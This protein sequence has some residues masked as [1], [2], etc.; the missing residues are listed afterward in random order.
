MANTRRKITIP[1]SNGRIDHT[2]PRVDRSKHN[3][4][5][6]IARQ[7]GYEI[8]S[9]YLQVIVPSIAKMASTA[10]ALHA[11]RDGAT[12]SVYDGNMSGV[13]RFA[14][15]I[16]PERSVELTV[17]PTRDALFAFTILTFD[18]LCLPDHALGTWFSR[19]QNLHI[20]DVVICPISL[21]DAIDLGLRHGQKA[22]FD[23]GAGKEISLTS[24]TTPGVVNADRREK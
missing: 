14:V 8:T 1:L 12:V 16:Y 10:A 17:A 7:E 4:S 13:P 6:D 15:S 22:I 9:H 3:T 20:L 18:L 21:D 2:V 5:R 23:L 19:A 11:E 24:C